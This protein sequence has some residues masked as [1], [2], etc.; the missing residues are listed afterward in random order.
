MAKKSTSRKNTAKKRAR[1]N[2][3]TAVSSTTRGASTEVHDR[4]KWRAYELYL[5]QG[6]QPGRHVQNWL[7]AERELL[8][9]HRRA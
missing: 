3:A 5:E 6:Q 1:M 7:D 8:A 4:I 9:K 2:T